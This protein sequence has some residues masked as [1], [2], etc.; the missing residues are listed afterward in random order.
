MRVTRV[1]VVLIVAAVI[2]AACS[3]GSQD[4]ST[5]ESEP[6]PPE[7]PAGA[8]GAGSDL[9]EEYLSEADAIPAADSDAG[10]PTGVELVPGGAPG[11]SRYVFRQYQDTVLASLVEG[12]QGEQTRCQEP[13]QP[14]SY[15]ELKE[16][17]E[18]GDPI[19][20]ELAMTD[21]ELEELVG[22]LDTLNGKV[23]EYEDVNT[24]CADGYISDRTQTANMGSHFYNRAALADGVVDPAFPDILLYARPDGAD[25]GGA[26][27]QCRNGVW[28]GGPVEIVGTSFLLSQSLVGDAHPDGFAGPLDNWHVHHNLCRGLGTDS[29]VPREACEQSGGSYSATLGWMIHAW[30]DEDHDSQL[31]V[32]S[33]WN[34]AIWPIADA[35]TIANRTQV[36]PA[37]IPDESEYSVIANF[38]FGEPLRVEAGQPVVFGNA[39]SVPH[40]VTGGE[41]ASDGTFDTGVFAPGANAELTFDEPGEVSFF[42]VL[43]PDMTG[44]VIVE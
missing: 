11:F 42:C 30:V 44:T 27:G 29:I 3:S 40:T 19:P 24:A 37:D 22:Q 7:A 38:D 13:A 9:L 10:I 41:G 18:S 14:C 28:E 34:P 35:E 8:A 16:L 12:P 6:E 20:T 31:G 39:D 1:L 21:A 36:R 32:F 43:H 17:H 5:S 2:A 23:D 4:L 25:P 33:M 15:I 26:L